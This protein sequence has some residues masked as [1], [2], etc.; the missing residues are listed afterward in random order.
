M[1]RQDKE[2]FLILKERGMINCYNY[3]SQERPKLLIR[4]WKKQ[5][6]TDNPAVDGLRDWM[7]MRAIKTSIGR[8]KARKK[9][10]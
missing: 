8:E 1:R 5:K 9:A 4:L 6:A 7:L 2:M 10:L 3:I